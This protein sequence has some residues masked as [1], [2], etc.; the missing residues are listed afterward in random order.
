MLYT[1]DLF[2]MYKF[3]GH[4]YYRAVQELV[5]DLSDSMKQVFTN[6]DE[7]Y[8]SHSEMVP[9]HIYTALDHRYEHFLM[10]VMSS[11]HIFVGMQV[12]PT[13]IQMHTDEVVAI[14]GWILHYTNKHGNTIVSH[15]HVEE[16]YRGNNYGKI[17][18]KALRDTVVIDQSSCEF[19]P[20]RRKK[21]LYSYCSYLQQ[22]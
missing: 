20:I 21:E 16:P 12:I 4:Q 6:Y 15:V 5:V 17:I 8:K 19:V 22:H 10:S 14:V 1:T 9:K 13:S 11:Y 2:T 7:G 18:Y 3:T